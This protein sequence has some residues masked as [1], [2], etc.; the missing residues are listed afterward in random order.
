MP[1]VE[2]YKSNL[3]TGGR[4]KDRYWLGIFAVFLALLAVAVAHHEPWM[5]EAQAWLLAKDANLEELFVQYLRYEGSPG[6]WH[7]ILMVPAKLGFPYVTLNIIAAVVA[8]SGVYAF[9]RYS[10]FPPAIKILFPFSYFVFFQYGVV[11]RSYCLVPLL[12]FVTAINYKEKLTR[13]FVFVIA[14]CLLENVSVH[15]FLVAGGIFAVH[16]WDVARE[17]GSLD[18]RTRVR[19]VAAAA[20]FGFVSIF[21]VLVL[22]PTPADHVLGSGY[23]SS[24]W[25]FIQVV[26]WAIPGSLILDEPGHYIVIQQAVSIVIF[27]T[28]LCW[29]RSRKLTLLYLVPLGL[30]LALFA[31]KYRNF[32]HDGV[33]FCLWIFVLWIGY[34]NEDERSRQNTFEKA[35]TIV[36]TLVLAVQVCWT[37]TAVYNDYFYNYSASR[38]VA[39]WIKHSGSPG[40]RIF[41]TGWKTTAIQ[42]YFDSNIFYNFN[43]G[44]GKRFWIWSTA[45]QTPLGLGTNVLRRIENDQP[46]IVVLASD[47]LDASMVTNPP[48]YVLEGLFPG[49]QFWKTG[50]YELNTY[51]I[52]RKMDERDLESVAELRYEDCIFCSRV[53]KFEIGFRRSRPSADFLKRK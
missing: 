42:P 19:Q 24:V 33:T 51:W 35:F 4:L 28:T 47:H 37:A 26:W 23:N 40:E 5:D 45:N 38:Q 52:F 29:L 17:W 14:L 41:A 21:V 30:L 15:T 16:V 48:G 39:D 31:I 44:S 53:R 8:A 25:N 7:L 49:Y 18:R 22:V 34:L 36:V 46:D 11:A 9:L 3:F 10:P 27:A 50:I 13:P 32:W 43:A 6:L 1:G 20:L 12:L 2:K